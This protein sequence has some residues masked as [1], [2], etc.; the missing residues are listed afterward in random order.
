[1]RQQDQW[2]NLQSLPTS[3]L[4]FIL[5]TPSEITAMDLQHKWNLLYGAGRRWVFVKD[6][7]HTSNCYCKAKGKKPFDHR[8]NIFLVSG[9]SGIFWGKL[10]QIN[11]EI[12]PRL[13]WYNNPITRQERQYRIIQQNSSL[14]SMAMFLM[15]DAKIFK[16]LAFHN[17]CAWQLWYGWG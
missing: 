1:M 4:H 2:D 9:R 15:S 14:H 10:L 8:G 12:L 13:S 17:V 11:H 5:Q 6:L 3:I 7:L 16:I